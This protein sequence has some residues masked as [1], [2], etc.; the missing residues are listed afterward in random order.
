MSDLY[1]HPPFN[2]RRW[3]IILAGCLILAGLGYFAY[4][5]YFKIPPYTVKPGDSI[6]GVLNEMPEGAIC[7]IYPGTYPG[8]LTIPRSG[9]TLK[10]T[11]T[12]QVVIDGQGA[13]NAV[14]INNVA[15][16]TLEN[17]VIRNSGGSLV[18]L[19][20]QKAMRNT[21]H[22]CTL[23]EWGLDESRAY[24][25]AV[26]SIDGASCTTVDLCYIDRGNH[27]AVWTQNPEAIS[28]HFSG[29]RHT[30]TN[31]IIWG[32]CRDEDGNPLASQED[33][34]D[35]YPMYKFNIFDVMCGKDGINRL[36]FDGTTISGNHLYG[37]HDDM[38]GIQGLDRNCTI[39]HNYIDAMGG[40]DC[41]V[42]RGASIGPVYITDN[43]M[44]NAGMSCFKYSSWKNGAGTAEKYISRNIYYS[45]LSRTY[46]R[47]ETTWY[48]PVLNASY[49]RFLDGEVNAEDYDNLHVDNNSVYCRSFFL[50]LK[51]D[52]GT[53]NTFT[54]NL[55]RTDDRSSCIKWFSDNTTISFTTFNNYTGGTNRWETISRPTQPTPPDAGAK[56][57]S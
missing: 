36:D 38:I 8:A 57:S 48:I 1:W 16:T 19:V 9:L 10:K 41:I 39:S 23:L 35:G 4:S 49:N 24:A 7:Y 15:D 27:E 26:D 22:R 45:T 14:L 44:V 52:S 25:G 34:G 11:G 6:Q 30:I 46:T 55:F 13:E 5:H 31:N 43:I 33:F 54:N 47:T 51:P 50:C 37:A 53:N 21:I 20:G 17:L 18:A 2:W 56:L 29:G 32:V 42:L 28:Y 3:L 40:A 12:G